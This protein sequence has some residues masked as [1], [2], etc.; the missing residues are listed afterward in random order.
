MSIKKD[1][2]FINLANNL[3]KNSNGYTGPNPSVGAIVVK[4]NKIISFGTTGISGR[5]HA[6][7]NALKKLSNKEKKNSTIYISLEPCAHKGKSPPCIDKIIK[8]KVKKVVYSINDVDPRTSGK[9]YKIL[10]SKNIKVK[11]NILKKFSKKIYKNY[12][13]SKINNKPYIIGK[14][15]ISS[16][17]YL[18]KNNNLYI[19]NE[20]SLKTTHIIRSRVNCIL[21]SSKTIN[22]D[23][24]RLNCRI[25]GLRNFSPKVVILDKNLKIKNNSY[26]VNNTKK[27]KLFIFFNKI[28]KKKIKYLKSKKINLI[29]TPV[30]KK[31]LDLNFI[32]NKLSKFEITSI[33]VEG[34]KSLI[35]SMIINNYFNE[36]Y[37]FT[38]PERLKK[39]GTLRFNNI[40]SLLSS[41]F[42]NI[43]YN[44]TFLDKDNLMHYY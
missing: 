31:N 9:S 35:S 8:S 22:D 29:H 16:D 19:T 43:S 32:L 44:E 42:R 26:I 7:F 2:Y 23:N 30:H 25:D 4:N 41:K 36:F 27:N 40:N 15:A 10:K 37:L 1:K 21:T 13:Y 11:R 17:C 14:L 5:P 6:E 28:N 38:S 12:F 39:R 18:K 34:G 33:L 20:F 24:P 3:A